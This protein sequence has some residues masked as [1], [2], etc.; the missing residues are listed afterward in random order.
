MTDKR[1]EEIEKIYEIVKNLN[2][3][4]KVAAERVSKQLREDVRYLRNYTIPNLLIYLPKSEDIIKQNEAMRRAIISAANQYERRLQI[5]VEF[6][7]QYQNLTKKALLKLRKYHW[8]VTSTLFPTLINKIVNCKNSQQMKVL[9]ISYHSD[10]NFE[11]LDNYLE[12]WGKSEIF[13]KR[14]KILKDSV[15]LLKNHKDTAKHKLNI[16]NLIIPALI[17]Q[18]EGIRKDTLKTLGMTEINI[19]SWQDPE[20]K[21]II[22]WQDVYKNKVEDESDFEKLAIYIFTVIL[23]QSE[24]DEKKAPITNFSRHK[25]SH[26][27]ITRYGNR[28]TTIKCFMILDF[29]SDLT[30]INKKD[31]TNE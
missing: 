27:E 21:Q 25:I 12:K 2:D 17:N 30:Q 22:K 23:F 5:A 31:L 15:E 1:T 3:E 7:N 20:S 26:G 6:V 9:F 11:A 29:L 18:I 10:N 8:F 24:R 16:D 19:N 13:K 4:F 14:M 28:E